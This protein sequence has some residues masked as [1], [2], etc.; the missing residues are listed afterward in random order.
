MGQMLTNSCQLLLSHNTFPPPPPFNALNDV[1]FDFVQ[2]EV[3]RIDIGEPEN[4]GMHNV[5]RRFL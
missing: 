4:T 5:F 2:I 1:C 3:E